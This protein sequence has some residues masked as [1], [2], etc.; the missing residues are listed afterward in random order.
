MDQGHLA[1]CVLFLLMWA[2][3]VDG[4]LRVWH[5]PAESTDGRYRYTTPGRYYRLGGHHYS[6]NKGGVASSSSSSSSSSPSSS[7][8]PWPSSSWCERGHYLSDF[9]V[10]NEV[11]LH[12]GG[13]AV[14]TM[15]QSVSPSPYELMPF[16]SGN[17]THLIPIHDW[18]PGLGCPFRIHSRRLSERD[19]LHATGRSSING[20]NSSMPRSRSSTGRRSRT[21]NTTPIAML[22][23]ILAYHNFW[24]FVVD[25]MAPLYQTMLEV[26]VIDRGKSESRP[27]RT[28]LVGLGARYAKAWI[29]TWL[30]AL[31]SAPFL[32]YEDVVGMSFDRA[33]VGLS[34]KLQLAP[35]I[36]DWPSPVANHPSGGDGLA[37]FLASRRG[38]GMFGQSQPLFQPSPQSGVAVRPHPPLCRGRDPRRERYLALARSVR[39]N[40]FGS[41]WSGAAG[42][43]AGARVS[44]SSPKPLLFLSKQQ[45]QQQHHHHHHQGHQGHQWQDTS[46][47]PPGVVPPATLFLRC[48]G[49]IPAER[50]NGRAI[51]NPD[52]VLG[53]L[54]EE[55]LPGRKAWLGERGGLPLREQIAVV[56]STRVFV[57][58]HGAVFANLI[59]LPA[60]A[61]VVQLWPY[62]CAD[63]SDSQE[64]LADVL[65]LPYYSWENRDADAA[66]I[67]IEEFSIGRSQPFSNYSSWVQARVLQTRHV[68]LH[69]DTRVDLE[70]FRAIARAARRDLADHPC[71]RLDPRRC[72]APLPKGGERLEH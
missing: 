26:G 2:G 66:F 21:H 25:T 6:S 12:E 36:D 53:V 5:Q 41:R 54:A 58:M 43:G 8:L 71:R 17:L 40:A 50:C 72:P 33:V 47:L 29:G 38:W 10:L 27:R 51:T 55:G 60:D 34:D 46:R 7:S 16:M 18:V 13:R 62:L 3:L 67:N 23:G 32:L 42:A 63:V 49:P 19:A 39:E 14:A 9:C 28:L 45:Q 15:P 20:S 64:R 37:S 1:N 59:F 24:H 4:I 56:E 48:G 65:G 22:F 69:M 11:E 30:R 31:S 35:A 52:A 70:A 61:V 68:A 57:A 44:A